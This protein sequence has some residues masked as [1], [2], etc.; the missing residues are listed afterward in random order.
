MNFKD[1]QFFLG[2]NSSA[3]LFVRY[4]DANIDELSFLAALT[5][6]AVNLHS[7]NCI[8]YIEHQFEDSFRK[9]YNELKEHTG[10]LELFT[11]EADLPEGDL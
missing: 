5:C 9:Y 1:V 10:S 8:K 2:D 6:K 4:L 11:P 3:Y 7:E